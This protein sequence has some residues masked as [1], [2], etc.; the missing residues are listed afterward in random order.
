[1]K[2]EKQTVTAAVPAKT[3]TKF[4]KGQLLGSERFKERRD[5]L[6]ALL[7]DGETYTVEEAEKILGD[8]MKG[9]VK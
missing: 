4:S 8:Y 2:E 9:Q 3:A 5:A 7:K 6:G 1:M